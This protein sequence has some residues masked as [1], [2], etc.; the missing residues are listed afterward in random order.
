MTRIASCRSNPD[1]QNKAVIDE[2]QA[3]IDYL[4]NENEQL[5][6][7]QRL[8]QEEMSRQISEIQERFIQLKN[9]GYNH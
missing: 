1:A 2:L 4:T 6:E 3:E 5:R 7:R 9:V 8:Q